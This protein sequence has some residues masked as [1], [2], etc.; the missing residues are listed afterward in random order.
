[1][2]SIILLHTTHRTFQRYL[3]IPVCNFDA[4]S[5]L[6]M[7]EF[8]QKSFWQRPEGV[9]GAIFLVAILT[10]LGVLVFSTLP[11][12]I[13]A[14]RNVFV[15]TGMI[16]GLAALLYV[17]FDRRMRTLVGYFYKSTMRSIT[18]LFVKV[19][20]I[21]ILKS[22]VQN[23]EENLRNM[24]RQIGRLRGQMHKLKEI[25]LNNQREIRSNL[26]LASE[27]KA[28]N[29][30]NVMILKSRKAGRLQESN[31]RLED[32]YQK[33][34]VLYRV[35][36]KMYENSQI[37]KEDIQDQV[38]VKEQ[39]RQAIHASNSAMR[40]AMSIIQGDPDKR[41]MFDAAME[42]IAEDVAGKVGEMENF[43]QLSSKFMESIDL[44]NGIFEEEGLRML[45]EWEE[46]GN[47]LLLGAEKSALLRQAADADDVLNLDAPAKQPVREAGHKNQYDAFFDLE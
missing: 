31:M 32:F 36:T 25:I 29:R 22:Y 41:A 20:P 38:E 10:G 40:S 15:L 1:M 23:L 28:N 2:L 5:I 18:G 3:C 21:A 6:Y 37:L 19:D 13:A 39:E 27:A 45:E 7:T 8:K 47:S 17:A 43:M 26:E 30:Q 11:L 34:E 42:A 35:L 9:T 44:Q 24:H 33:M 12:W 14:M 4:S 46:K 16:V